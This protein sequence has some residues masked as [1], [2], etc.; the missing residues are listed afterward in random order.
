MIDATALLSGYD[1]RF[2]SRLCENAFE[3]RT[4]RI[5]FSIA[6]CQQHPPVRLASVTTK[7]RWKFYAQVERLSFH[8]AWVIS[9]PVAPKIR[10]PLY[11]RKRTSTPLYRDSDYSGYAD[12]F[13]ITRVTRI[14]RVL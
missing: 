8:T 10:L 13:K 9:G 11:P 4:L 7:S 3:P 5:V 6:F 1:I 14:T 12:Y 2:G